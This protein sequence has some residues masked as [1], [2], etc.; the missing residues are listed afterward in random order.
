MLLSTMVEHLIAH[1]NSYM[2]TI[3]MHKQYSAIKSKSNVRQVEWKY[4]KLLS[5]A[6]NNDILI[7]GPGGIFPTENT[8]KLIFLEAV[9][10]HWKLHGKRVCFFGFGVNDNISKSNIKLWRHIAKRSDCFAT[11]NSRFLR[12]ASISESKRIFT[13]P[14]VAFASDI[15]EYRNKEKDDES[16]NRIGIA[17]ANLSPEIIDK[18]TDVWTHV[19]KSLIDQKYYVDLI[20]FYK[21]SDDLLINRIYS[22]ISDNTKV[23]L[24]EYK[25]V[26]KAIKNWNSYYLTI[27]MR[28]HSN[29]ISTL[30]NVPFLP[31]AY[32]V[33]TKN[34]AEDI[35]VGEYVFFWNES[36]SGYL[37]QS[38]KASSDEIISNCMKALADRDIIQDKTESYGIIA[39]KNVEDAFVRLYAGI[40]Q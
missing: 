16:P 4:G 23:R 13:M 30:F 8:K 14:D 36:N 20:A 39:R 31:I 33:K 6:K 27:C 22:N 9:V 26:N 19:V 25:N 5:E 15:Y 1:N 34:L 10:E 24:F 38:Y 18:Q 17:V 3:A 7:I 29:V 2:L 40:D 35:G 37:S 21:D 32:G 28:F 11:R 12:S